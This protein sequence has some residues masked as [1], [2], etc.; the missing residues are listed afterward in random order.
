[1]VL[2]DSLAFSASIPLLFVQK[3]PLEADFD[4]KHNFRK[5]LKNLSKKRSVTVAFCGIQS[6]MST[7]SGNSISQ[8][9][10]TATTFK[11][12]EEEP[13]AHTRHDPSA[14]SSSGPDLPVAEDASDSCSNAVDE[15][16][17]IVEYEDE[18]EGADED[19][20]DNDDDDDDDD[21]AVGSCVHV[22]IY[23][24][25]ELSIA[26]AIPPGVPN[27]TSFGPGPS[28]VLVYP[29]CACRF[30]RGRFV[31]MHSGVPDSYRLGLSIGV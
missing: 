25:G 10:P 23:H 29:L 3:Y 21:D 13:D 22:F 12:K 11:K 30:P 20:D 31:S 24:T 16:D 4:P 9:K 28:I 15:S 18:D 7:C 27:A 2:S 26:A 17:T 19:E 6:R 14:R 5:Q 1:M 8:M